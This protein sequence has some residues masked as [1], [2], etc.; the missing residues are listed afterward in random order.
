[1]DF[2]FFTVQSQCKANVKPNLGDIAIGVPHN[3]IPRAKN[4]ELENQLLAESMFFR[5]GL[6][7]HFYRVSSWL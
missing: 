4:S 6:A 7:L 3:N 2:F 1:M 5:G